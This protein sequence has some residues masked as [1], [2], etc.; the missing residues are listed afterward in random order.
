M[1]KIGNYEFEI[2]DFDPE[3]VDITLE[4][5]TEE[6]ARQ[7]YFMAKVRDQ[8]RRS[9]WEDVASGEALKRYGKEQ[10]DEMITKKFFGI[11]TV[12]TFGCRLNIMEGIV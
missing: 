4:P 9:F 11:C 12:I 6:P 3:K 5:P 1:I 2:N 10:L 8:L 7:Y